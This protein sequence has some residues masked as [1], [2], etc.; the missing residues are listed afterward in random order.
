MFFCL[1]LLHHWSVLPCEGVALF[2]LFLLHHL[3]IWAQCPIKWSF[4]D[5]WGYLLAWFELHVDS[6]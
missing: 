4:S 5:G 2:H 3:V 6:L 1:T